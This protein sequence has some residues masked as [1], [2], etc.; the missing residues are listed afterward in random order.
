MVL[1]GVELDPPTALLVFSQ[2]T[3]VSTNLSLGLFG[4]PLPLGDTFLATA[5]S[6][7]TPTLELASALAHCLMR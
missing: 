1:R 5:I 4:H 7:D 3:I 6:S 2:Q